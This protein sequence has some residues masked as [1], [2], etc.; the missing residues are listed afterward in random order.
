MENQIEKKNLAT[1]LFK[2]LDVLF[3]ISGYPDGIDIPTIVR[4]IQQP[5]SSTVRILDSL[6]YYGLIDRRRRQYFPADRLRLLVG[7]D[8]RRALEIEYHRVLERIN[9]GIGELVVLSRLEGRNI[10]PLAAIEGKYRVSVKPNIGKAY[11]A[12]T[13]AMGKIILSL[14]SDIFRSNC[15][16]RLRE[17]L[18]LAREHHLAF[19]F[20]ES[21]PDLVAIGTWLDVPAPTSPVVS[22]AWPSFRFT[23]K[24]AEN[25][26]AVLRTSLP[27]AAPLSRYKP[28]LKPFERLHPR[29]VRGSRRSSRK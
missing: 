6:E 27:E 28:P 7:S 8:P 9:E 18:E 14:R 29:L 24:E 5:R 23:R 19:N 22:I 3:L 11:P 16:K 15:P 10:I 17:E 2:G 21:E 13:T 26:I 20:D 4:L 1:S 25:A 12:E